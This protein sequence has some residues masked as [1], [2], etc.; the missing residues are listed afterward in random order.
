[1][2]KV[3]SIFLALSMLIVPVGAMS[4]F[5]DEGAGAGNHHGSLMKRKA[6][7]V[8]IVAEVA[9]SGNLVLGMIRAGRQGK[10]FSIAEAPEPFYPRFAKKLSRLKILNKIRNLKCDHAVVVFEYRAKSLNCVVEYFYDEYGRIVKAFEWIK[11]KH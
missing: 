9:K 3:L 11:R 4:C 7:S 1:M 2:K 10:I 6:E 8:Q 5:A